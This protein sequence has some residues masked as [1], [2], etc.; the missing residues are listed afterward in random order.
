[1]STSP[2]TQDDI[3]RL[4]NKMDDISE[5]LETKMDNIIE[6]H[7]KLIVDMAKN[8]LRINGLAIDVNNMQS[9]QKSD[10]SSAKGHHYII[11]GSLIS[12]SAVVISTLVIVFTR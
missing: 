6:R 4:E 1:M 11:Y 2:A 10:E 8:E 12:M 3:R 9:D 5:R 7:N